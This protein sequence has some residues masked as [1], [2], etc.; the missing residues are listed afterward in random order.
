[1]TLL[2]NHQEAYL[3]VLEWWLREWR[4]AV[5]VSKSTVIIF[6]RAGRRFLKARPTQLFREPI[7]YVHSMHYLGGD[8]RYASDLVASNLSGQKE[9]CLKGVG[10]SPEQEKWHLYQKWGPALQ[11]DHP[12]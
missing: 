1:L 9:S 5:I 11:A 6:A 2:V 12:F 7:Q 3:S 8:S 4:L 10:S